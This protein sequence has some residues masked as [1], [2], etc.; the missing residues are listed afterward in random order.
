MMRLIDAD[1]L[2]KKAYRSEMWNRSTQ[3]FDL[4]VVDAEDVEDAP[5]IDA[6]EV[7]RCKDCEEYIP[8]LE[9]DYIC[10]RI[11]SYFGNTKP[12]DFCSR[13]VRKTD[14][15]DNHETFHTESS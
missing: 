11:G 1:G 2:I 5:T 8:W 14:M 6:V 4:F 3:A 9:G 13:G 15:E 12:N 7:V 10:G